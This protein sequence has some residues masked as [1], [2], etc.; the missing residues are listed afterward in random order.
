VRFS[1]TKSL[2]K[3]MKVAL[4]GCAVWLQSCDALWG[5]FG[6]QNPN[7]C[8][9][10]SA[11]CA[12]DEVCDLPSQICVSALGI[13][14]VVPAAASGRG[15]TTMTLRGQRFSDGA[16]VFVDD[17]PAQDVVFVSSEELRFTLP[18]STAGRWRVPVAVENPSQH[19]SERRDL[20]AYYAETLTF[21]SR[22]IAVAGLP[23]GAASGDWN[24]DHALDLAV[25]SLP[26]AGVQIFLGDGSGGF[27]S[28][29]SVTVGSAQMAT[30]HI[31]TIDGNHDGTSDLVV[32][33]GGSLTLLYGDGQ[34]GFPSR[35]VLY[36]AGTGHNLRALAAGD[37]DGDGRDDIVIT[38]AAA[39]DLSADVVL[40]RSG[41]DG[42]FSS[43]NVIDSGKPAK[44][45]AIA[46]FTGDA[47]GDVL[48]GIA[49]T[50]LTLWRNEDGQAWTRVDQPISGCSAEGAAVGDLN[51]DGRLDLL[52]RCDTTLRTLLNAGNAMFTPLPDLPPSTQVSPTLALADA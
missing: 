29:N 39:D 22:A 50:R 35:R 24:G 43:R 47:R 41:E 9:V 19:R 11:G 4:L 46:D 8:V 6:R 23:I 21:E 12:A 45:L 27:S 3:Q 33:A 49:S 37:Y 26:S 48:V 36:T 25:I 51:H 40:L 42:L 52:L 31:L 18:A 28:G 44:T 20:F 38:D 1:V 16:K 34:G 32:A 13:D 15:G 14:S 2:N 30:Q 17:Q 7:N 5:A 10:S